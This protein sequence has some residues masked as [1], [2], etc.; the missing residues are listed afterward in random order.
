MKDKI[1]ILKVKNNF[2][3]YMPNLLCL[4]YS[5]NQIK[6]SIHTL[7]ISKLAL[8]SLNTLKITELSEM[9]EYSKND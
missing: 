5:Q 3:N 8:S 6:L 1:S 2:N 4:I 7:K 9:T